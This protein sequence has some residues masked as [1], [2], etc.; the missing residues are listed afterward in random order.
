M[1]ATQ[2]NK[3]AFRRL[4]LKM[5]LYMFYRRTVSFINELYLL[6]ITNRHERS[7][8]NVL[9]MDFPSIACFFHTSMN[10][11]L[12]LVL[13]NPDIPC[14]CKQCRSKS[15]GFWRSQLFWICTVVMKYLN[16]Y[17][18][19]WSSNLIGWKI[20]SRLGILIYSAGQG[21][22]RLHTPGRFSVSFSKFFKVFQRKTI[23]VPSCLRFCTPSPFWKEIYSKTK[24]L[25]PVGANTFL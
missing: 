18:Q 7:S 2:M 15:V 6:S 14:L 24:K 4:D 22:S 5:S 3:N 20:R 1:L 12:T 17:E 8:V 10:P 23:C 9:L 16:L 25:L 11:I 21:L 19:L 13:L